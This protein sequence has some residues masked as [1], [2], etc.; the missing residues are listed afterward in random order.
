MSC[1][2]EWDKL[3]YMATFLGVI[4]A[5]FLIVAAVAAMDD[6]F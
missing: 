1:M 6:Y 4:V 3:Q 5:V 2:T